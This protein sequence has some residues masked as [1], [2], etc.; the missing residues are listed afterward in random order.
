MVVCILLCVCPVIL[1]VVL[2]LGYLSASVLRDAAHIRLESATHSCA[3]A[4]QQWDRYFALAL[5]NTRG[6]PDI[7]GM[8]AEEQRP[9]V[10]QMKRSYNRIDIVR[11]TG[12]DGK[13]IVR[14][15]GPAPV[16]YSDRRWFKACMSGEDLFRE[17]L[18]TKTT[19]RPALNYSTP[20]RG[21]DG[22]PVGVLSAVTELATVTRTLGDLNPDPALLMWV[23]DQ[24]GR[25]LAHPSSVTGP[26]LQDWSDH[27]PVRQA[28]RG[29]DGRLEFADASGRSWISQSLKMANGWTVVV[30]MDM[31]AALAPGAGVMRAAVWMGVGAAAL[32]GLLTWLAA[33]RMLAPIRRLT[34]GAREFGAGRWDHRVRVQPGDEFGLLGSTFNRMA[35]QIEEACREMESEVRQRTARLEQLN[36]ELEAH[37]SLADAQ[38][39]DMKV[40]LNGLPGYATLK[41]RNG[42]Y[43]TANAAA[44]EAIGQPLEQIIGATDAELLPP[45]QADSNRVDDMRLLSGEVEMIEREEPALHRNRRIW[46]FTRKLAL[47]GADGR[48]ERILGFSLD[49]TARREAQATARQLSQAVEQESS[50]VVITDL[51]G[52]IT[53]V[54]KAF[55]RVTGYESFEVM[56]ENPRILKSGLT[57]AA[58]FREMW[59]TLRSGREWRG[60]FQNRRKN[61]EHYWE[62][63]IISPLTDEE[64]RVTHY[65][66]VKEDITARKA[67]EQE[68]ERAARLDRLTALPNRALLLDRLQQ[69]IFRHQRWPERKFIVMFLDFDR[70]K[71][72]ND[73]LGHDAGDQ[74]LI[75][76]AQ[77]LRT[78]IRVADSVSRVVEGHTA[79]RLGGDEFVILLDS[80]EAGE[81]GEGTGEAMKIAERLLDALAEPYEIGEMRIV[82]TASIGVVTADGGYQRAEEVLR[83]ADTAMYEAK[84]AGKGRVAL[85]DARMREGVRRRMDIESE[86]RHAVESEQFILHYQPIV[87]LETGLIESV[88]ALVRWR[89][90]TRGM[91][92][93]GEFIPIAE[94][95]G[96]IVPLGE[97]VLRA[98]LAQM[99]LW[100][101]HPGAIPIPSVSVNL[102]RMQLLT[103]G[104]VDRI[105]ALASAAGVDPGVVHLEITESTVMRDTQAAA[106]LLREL[107]QQ[108]FKL[109]LDDF[110]TGYSSLSCLH[111]FAID[112]IK[113]DRSFVTNL[114]RGHDYAALVNAIVTLAGN[115]RIRVVAEGVETVE[116]M[117]MLQ[118]LDCQLAQGYYFGRPM[119]AEELQKYR[120]PPRGG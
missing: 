102:S 98:A 83:D 4:I 33:H 47:R 92:S 118:S 49:V 69:A 99:A 22:K 45:D 73:S 48:V 36:A 44:C 52:Q 60:E 42:E 64:G 55:S 104:I 43:L 59:D 2:G 103:P 11:T 50:P 115:L 34:Q 110:G 101:R 77:R 79:A 15:D 5:Q 39:R 7:V 90:P 12:P 97:W 9:V 66:A 14:T 27:P 72:V 70:F 111:Q 25:V 40:L 13:S 46:V 8:K 112:T 57:P 16:D 106:A 117:T 38:S 53:F 119:P 56:G 65:V 10:E 80:I 114:S 63:A 41:G 1:A 108:G 109:D 61:G 28:L 76:I 120:P 93:P 30:Q 82:S 74:L 17:V 18:V 68:L 20:I 26:E 24:E 96:V 54:N 3:A 6:Q 29:I 105:G 32:A 37:R 88:E 23:V 84:L 85:F 21:P 58:T 107:R 87:S 78:H 94:E 116:Q 67:M 35:G 19:G 75:K 100:Q 89:H 113:I 95:S 71:I 31:G 81:G 62:L 86:L 91:I 51:T